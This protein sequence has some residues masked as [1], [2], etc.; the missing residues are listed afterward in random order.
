MKRI[1]LLM[2]LLVLLFTMNACFFKKEEANPKDSQAHIP[3][4]YRLK[5]NI[6]EDWYEPLPTAEDGFVS[7]LFGLSEVIDGGQQESREPIDLPD[8]EELFTVEEMEEF[9]EMIVIVKEENT[10]FAM[11]NETSV[12]YRLYKTEPA[13]GA[14]PDGSAGFHITDWGDPQTASA[15]M[16]ILYSDAREIEGLGKRAH[17]NQFNKIGI[18]ATDTAILGVWAEFEPPEGGP[19]VPA[20]EEFMLKFARF[21]YDRFMEKIE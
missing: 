15:T 17:I 3:E 11:E 16:G 14:F 4:E 8:A 6:P 21:V 18:L 9:F 5:T 7:P 2:F 20:D 13:T 10:S 19:N 1:F 12:E